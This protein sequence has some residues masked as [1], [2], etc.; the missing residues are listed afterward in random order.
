M[1]KAMKRTVV[2]ADSVVVVSVED[3][4]YDRDD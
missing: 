3:V 4:V 2:V 1:E